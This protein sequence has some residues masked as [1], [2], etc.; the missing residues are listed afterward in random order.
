ML[1]HIMK[2]MAYMVLEYDLHVSTAI[3]YCTVWLSVIF[4][5]LNGLVR[6]SMTQATIFIEDSVHERSAGFDLFTMLYVYSYILT[7]KLLFITTV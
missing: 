2:N 3:L 6:T 7:Y 1:G 4:T 5:A